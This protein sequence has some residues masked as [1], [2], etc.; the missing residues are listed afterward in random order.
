VRQL[1]DGRR[2]ILNFLLPGDLIGVCDQAHPV[3]TTTAAALTN[4][5]LCALPQKPP[6]ALHAAYI[7]S[8]ALE[9]S[10]L[11]AQITRLG[12][13]SA[14]ERMADLMLELLERLEL[15]GHAGNGRF[16]LPI[17]QEVLA[18]ALGL[19]PVH[20]NRTLQAMRRDREITLKGREFTI[21]SPSGLARSIGR[22][23]SSP[24]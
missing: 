8:R 2:Q 6:P 18:D 1:A 13:M 22:I 20:V 15:A 17:T 14:H 16:L 3:A 7:A 10:Y 9:H 12:R 23:K 24:G 21:I 19:T 11:L 5:H 4:V